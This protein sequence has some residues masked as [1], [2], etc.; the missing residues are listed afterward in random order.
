MTNKRIPGMYFDPSKLNKTLQRQ[1]FY[2]RTT[3]DVYDKLSKGTSF[4]VVDCKK[5]GWQVHLDEGKPY[6]AFNI[7]WQV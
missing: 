4:I 2:S 3:A 1:P 7:I 6:L 5:D